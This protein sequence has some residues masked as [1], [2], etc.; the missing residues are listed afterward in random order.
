MKNVVRIA[1]AFMPL[2]SFSTY[3]EETQMVPIEEFLKSENSGKDELGDA[4]KSFVGLRC[5]SLMLIWSKFLRDNGKNDLS[6]EFERSA[7]LALG[8]AK[9]VKLFNEEYGREQIRIMVGG[10]K[11]RWLK[12]KAMTGNVSDDRLIKSDM[13]LCRQ[14]FQ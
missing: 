10:Y 8:L 11:E 7:E 13:L 6:Q 14:I 3:A 4:T 5:T 2:L 9:S 12:A 1:I